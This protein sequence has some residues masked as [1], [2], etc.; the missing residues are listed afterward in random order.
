[1][2]ALATVRRLKDQPISSLGRLFQPFAKGMMLAYPC[3]YEEKIP[4]VFRIGRE[5]CLFACARLFTCQ[6]ATRTG[7]RI[8]RMPADADST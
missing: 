3:G 5:L 6:A 8:K 2:T 1:L 7:V 4:Y